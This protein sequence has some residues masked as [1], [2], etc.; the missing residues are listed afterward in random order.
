M[1]ANRVSVIS[2]EHFVQLLLELIIVRLQSAIRPAPT[3]S[4]TVFLDIARAIASRKYA[5]GVGSRLFEC[6][7]VVDHPQ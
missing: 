5:V 4:A 1:I 7:A 3:G 6:L 2:L